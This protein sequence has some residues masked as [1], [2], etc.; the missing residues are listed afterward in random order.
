MVAQ[1]SVSMSS[2]APNLVAGRDAETTSGGDAGPWRPRP[3][4]RTP[5][6]VQRPRR[7][8]VEGVQEAAEQV[9]EDGGPRPD[10]HQ[11]EGEQRQQHAGVTCG[12]TKP[13]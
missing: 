7:V 5:T 3:P 13:C 9:E 6:L 4:L 12:R 1:R 8:A 2:M 11:E 10:G